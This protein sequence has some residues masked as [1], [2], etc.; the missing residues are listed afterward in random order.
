[1]LAK[2]RDWHGLLEAL[3]AYAA[4]EDD[5]GLYPYPIRRDGLVLTDGLRFHGKWLKID[6]TKLSEHRET[7][8]DISQL[9]RLTELRFLDLSRTATRDLSPL[10][11]LGKLA[12]LG[13]DYTQVV[14]LEPL[15]RLARLERLTVSGTKVRDISPLA[16]LVELRSLWFY[17]TQVVDVG[18]V[19]GLT[20]LETL[21]M[22]LSRVDDSAPSPPRIS[23]ISPLAGL[24]DL[25][26]LY[27]TCTQ[28]TDLSPLAG[29]TK[30][31]KLFLYGTPA[32]RAAV[33]ELRRALP[34]TQ[35]FGP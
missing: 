13:L 35:F 11:G 16:D 14:D 12:E 28:V 24:H 4:R 15:R 25:Q 23:D 31:K 26:L 32:P 1:M 10:A 5:A 7:I 33:D 34:D 18:A 6:T 27:L 22:G 8:E 19:A 9:A 3:D 21:S 2:T 29:L 20:R 30:L 17:D